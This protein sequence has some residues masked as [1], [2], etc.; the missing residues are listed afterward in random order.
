LVTEL[1]DHAYKAFV[2]NLFWKTS[3]GTR[4]EQVQSILASHDPW[5]LHAASHNAAVQLAPSL[6]S[7]VASELASDQAISLEDIGWWLRKN[8]TLQQCIAL[9]RELSPG[10][11]AL[12]AGSDYTF[13]F[14]IALSAIDPS[15]DRLLEAWQKVRDQDAS[16]PQT[17]STSS[18][19]SAGSIRDWARE[20]GR[21]VGDRG[22]IPASIVSEYMAAT[23]RCL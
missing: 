11:P 4:Q 6:E 13:G 18:Q 1:S 20:H 22:R 23:Q 2:E 8:A 21:S 10:H 14:V 16:S 17:A 12:P 19:T 7:V 9:L 3:G 15:A 5:D